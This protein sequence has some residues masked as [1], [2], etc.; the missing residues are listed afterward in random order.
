MAFGSEEQKKKYLTPLI[1]GEAILATAITEPDAGSD[2]TR[3][4]TTA[5][6]DGDE[7]V[8]NGSKM[9]ITNGTL[10]DNVIVFCKTHPEEPSPQNQY[11]C[12]IVKTDTKGFEAN[13]LKN[14]LG[15]RASDTA[16]LSLKDVRVP[17]TN[18][19]G[20]EKEGFKQILNL[21]VTFKSVYIWFLQAKSNEDSDLEIPAPSYRHS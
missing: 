4:E 13:K 16:E 18:L 19:I 9:F 6:R 10:A 20:K 12:I 7:Y 21:L 15:I 5:V 17:V 14:K 11:S 3:A 8:V 2:V 1:E